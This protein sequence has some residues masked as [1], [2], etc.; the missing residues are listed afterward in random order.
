MMMRSP[1]GALSAAPSQCGAALMVQLVQA[2]D[3]RTKD[4]PYGGAL[5]VLCDA[6]DVGAWK[7]Q[8]NYVEQLVETARVE[9][10]KIDFWAVSGL[11]QLGLYRKQYREL[12]DDLLYVFN[13]GESVNSI[14]AN[15]ENGA[16]VLEL[17]QAIGAKTAA[18][19]AP[20]PTPP[21]TTQWAE[22]AKWVVP[23]LVIASVYMFSGDRGRN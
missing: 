20:K 10:E 23:I 1:V 14:I 4:N 16:C 13:C 11:H 7:S 19:G 3:G 2:A 18:P 9:A 15:I 8:A 6:S 17:L 5:G 12:P 21:L 22:S